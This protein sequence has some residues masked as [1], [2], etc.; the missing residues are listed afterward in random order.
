M[1]EEDILKDEIAKSTLSLRW[2][3]GDNVELPGDFEKWF[4]KNAAYL[5]KT[6]ELPK[7]LKVS[8]ST[9]S[10]CFHNSQLASL[11]SNALKYYEGLL[12]G[13][14]FK[15]CWHHGFNVCDQGVLDV[16]YLHHKEDFHND[17]CRD[18]YFIYYGVHI[19]DDF[20]AKYKAKLTANS[21]QHSPL[22]LEFYKSVED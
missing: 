7:G 15:N 3:F 17:N 8:Q 21:N 6:V 9:A 13:P 2:D 16:T 19:P 22:L 11:E 12:Y 5:G 4:F 1:S 20:L 18:K 14:E 10:Q